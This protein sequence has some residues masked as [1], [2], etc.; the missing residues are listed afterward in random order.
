MRLSGTGRIFL[1]LCVEMAFRLHGIVSI[2]PAPRLGVG[3][4]ARHVD[5]TTHLGFG[6]GFGYLD[7]VK[8]LFDRFKFLHK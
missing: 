7:R 5:E 8:S 2:G 4:L 1:R 6:F 3:T